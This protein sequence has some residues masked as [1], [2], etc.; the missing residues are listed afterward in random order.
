MH[1]LLRHFIL[2]FICVCL[3]APLLVR[4]QDVPQLDLERTIIRAGMH[5]ID[6]QL[7]L[8]PKQR[9][10]GLMFRKDMPQHEGML[11]VFERPAI[12]CFWMKNTDLPLS[13]AFVADDGR[14]VN[15]V[16]MQPHTTQSHCST[17]A[18]RY[19]LE[20]HQGWFSKK[21]I[22]AGH[23]LKGAPFKPASAKD[24]RAAAKP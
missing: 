17:E 7:A 2:N 10:I 22:V 21:N 9:E 16:D 15:L 18:V 11:F 20:V 23:L 19:V 24:G 8:T 14:I 3:S 12:Q 13:A 4:A 6:T 1:P 5:Q